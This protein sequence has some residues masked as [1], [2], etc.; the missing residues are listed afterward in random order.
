MS[1]FLEQFSN[2]L[3]THQQLRYGSVWPG[4]D[5]SHFVVQY[6]E[7]EGPNLW[8]EMNFSHIFN[9]K[10]PQFKLKH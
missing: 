4:G 2:F 7:L 5:L 1:A 9:E 10:I 6:M 8:R 3:S